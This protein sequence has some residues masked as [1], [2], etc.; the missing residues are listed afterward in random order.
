MQEARSSWN[1]L[2]VDKNGFECQLTLRDEDENALAEK[3]AAITARITESGGKP[4]VRRNGRQ[5]RDN[6]VDSRNGGGNASNGERQDKTY[7][8]EMGVRRRT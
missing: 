7:V 2:Y 1:T 4:V 5:A 3:I 6:V 8:D